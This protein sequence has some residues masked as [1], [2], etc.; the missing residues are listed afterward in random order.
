VGEGVEVVVDRLVV[1]GTARVEGDLVYQSGR[2]AQ[3]GNAEIEGNVIR[4]SALP[5]NVR[6]RGL[7]LLTYVLAFFS[8]TT[9]GLLMSW[10]WPARVEGAVRAGREYVATWVTGLSV[11][12]APLLAGALVALL[13]GLSPPEA[14]VPLALVLAPAVLGL[15]GVAF[16][17]ALAGIVPVSGLVGRRLV[18]KRSVAAAFLVG[19]LILAVLSVI[20]IVGALVWVAAVPLGI[21]A[22]LRHGRQPAEA[23]PR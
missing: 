15:G 4:R 14:G 19:W 6:L 5:P 10:A 13:V 18:K 22:W 9:L 21:G 8:V 23:S 16:V 2:E 1:T 7:R 11:V 12:V 20:P 17:L 3:I